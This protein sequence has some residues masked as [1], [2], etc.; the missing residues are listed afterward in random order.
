MG[1]RFWTDGAPGRTAVHMEPPYTATAMTKCHG[2]SIFLKISRQIGAMVKMTTK[3]ET[4]PNDR[5]AVMSDRPMRTRNL[6]IKPLP[7]PPA[8][9][10]RSPILMAIF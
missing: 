3:P 5:I 9:W 10:A 2:M 8:F 6:G 1:M 4:P 7:P